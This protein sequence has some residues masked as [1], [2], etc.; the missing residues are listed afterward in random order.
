M[1]YVPMLVSCNGLTTTMVC[2]LSMLQADAGPG[3][4]LTLCTLVVWMKLVSYAHCHWDL[5]QARRAGELRVG[6]RGHPLSDPSWALLQYP[7]NLG[8]GNLLFYLAVPSLVYQVRRGIEQQQQ[9]QR[10]S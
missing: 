9:Q 6:E 1:K 5:R 10:V 7:E 3:I 2:L 8:A 4:L